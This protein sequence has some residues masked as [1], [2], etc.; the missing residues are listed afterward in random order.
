MG[1]GP[2]D[3]Q[4]KS[5]R[6]MNIAKDIDIAIFASVLNIA[7]TEERNEGLMEKVHDWL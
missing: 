2:S 4:A 6:A 5:L 1:K 7:R 3:G